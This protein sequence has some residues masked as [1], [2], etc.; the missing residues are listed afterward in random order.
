MMMNKSMY[1]NY[2]LMSIGITK[3]NTRVLTWKSPSDEANEY[4]KVTEVN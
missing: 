1:R 3:K 4:S 2:Q